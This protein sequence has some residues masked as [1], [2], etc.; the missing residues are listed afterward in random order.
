MGLECQCHISDILEKYNASQSLAAGVAL[1]TK[2]CFHVFAF[3]F[4]Y[5]FS[6]PFIFIPVG[7]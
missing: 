1:S 5:F 4:I 2:I 3:R 6:L 7:L